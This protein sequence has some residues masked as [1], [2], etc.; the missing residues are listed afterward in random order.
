MSVKWN[1]IMSN[2]LQNWNIDNTVPDPAERIKLKR[3]RFKNYLAIEEM[4]PIKVKKNNI[5]P[6]EA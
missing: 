5:K 1:F 3:K 2:A 6:E 4:K